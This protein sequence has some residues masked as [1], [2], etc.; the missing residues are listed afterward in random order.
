MCVYTP[1]RQ[2]IM[3]TYLIACGLLSLQNSSKLASH[4]FNE[5]V[6]GLWY[7]SIMSTAGPPVSVHYGVVVM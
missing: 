4:Y 6:I 5:V 2:Y 3:T 7:Y 1:M